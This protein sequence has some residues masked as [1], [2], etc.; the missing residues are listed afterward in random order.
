[1][2]KSG[3]FHYDFRNVK[4]ILET[5]AGYGRKQIHRALDQ[6]SLKTRER[7]KKS[8]KSKA[9]KIDLS[10]DAL[11]HPIKGMPLSKIA[12]PSFPA[13]IRPWSEGREK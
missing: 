8:P 13:E 2:S 3:A 12:L 11:R 7:T 5:T 6:V 4:P 10:I 9:Q 1:M